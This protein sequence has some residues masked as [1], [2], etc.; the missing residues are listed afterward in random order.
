MEE[1]NAGLQPQS[2]VTQWQFPTRRGLLLP[3]RNWPGRCDVLDG[4]IHNV[5]MTT[6]KGLAPVRKRMTGAASTRPDQ[7]FNSYS[8]DDITK[9]R[10][11]RD[12]R[13]IRW[14]VSNLTED[15]EMELTDTSQSQKPAWSPATKGRQKPSHPPPMMEHAKPRRTPATTAAAHRECS[16]KDADMEPREG[17]SPKPPA[18]NRSP[19][20]TISQPTTAS[21]GGKR[22]S[23]K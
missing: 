8:S 2:C 18:W 9:D 19:A 7:E 23:A 13:A 20:T 21:P 12:Q 4:K 6:T 17:K 15:A 16:S 22:K 3:R 5:L 11:G 14:L 1:P 10:E